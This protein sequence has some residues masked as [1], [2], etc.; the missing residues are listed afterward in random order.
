LPKGFENQ[1]TKNPNPK[2]SKIRGTVG[3]SVA[4]IRKM[5]YSKS[6][7][8]NIWLTLLTGFLFGFS[9]S[10]GLGLNNVVSVVL[11]AV[12]ATGVLV[13]GSLVAY[14]ITQTVVL[15]SLAVL[16]KVAFI[17]IADFRIEAG[18]FQI[19]YL[20]ILLLSPLL[21]LINKVRLATN[22]LTISV[23][24]QLLT[25]LM[26]AILVQ[27]LRS[28]MPSNAEFAVARMFE[29]EDNAGI[30]ETLA[31]SLKYGFTPQA[32]QFGEFVNSIYLTTAG[33]ISTLSDSNNSGLL[34]ALTHY[35]LTL[36]FMAWVPI[37]ALFAIVFSG[38]DHK[39]E[40][41]IAILFVSTIV[42]GI[43]FWPFETLGHTSVISG[44]LFAISLLALTLNRRF[45]M[46]HAIAYASLVTSFGLII[47]T[48]WFPLMPFA[49]ATVALTY[50]YLLHLEYR[51]GNVKIVFV[52]AGILAVLIAVLL[53][54]V[55]RLASNSAGYLEMQGGTRSPTVGL[56]ILTLLLVAVVTWRLL[57]SPGSTGVDGQNLFIAVVAVLVSSNVYLLFSA[58]Q[59]NQGTFGYGATKYLLTTISFSLPVFWMLA[60]EYLKPTN[61]RVIGA[62]GLVL[63]LSILMIQPDSRKVP[64]AI[65]APQLTSRQFLAPFDIQKDETQASSI[66]SAIGNALEGNP[67][68]VICV[69]DYGFPVSGG[70]PNLYSYFCNRWAGSLN[71]DEE[72]FKWGAVPIG[73]NAK[74][75]LSD[76]RN[77]YKGEEVVI[78]R[79][80]RP[81]G[82]VPSSLDAS[83]TWWFEYVD[84]SWKVIV[85]K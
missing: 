66:A 39:D 42:L 7:S 73:V 29:G 48:T 34:P 10:V 49:A 17:L 54:G 69:S 80:P 5:V 81:G 51:K 57:R 9:V 67:D 15:A 79:I 32:A 31:G 35:N 20:L 13:T 64:A 14:L 23:P 6:K 82:V 1:T 74:E 70:E 85:T 58:L 76:F 28:R 2:I 40:A 71:N 19:S 21:S 78:I 53:P 68:H 75:T 24:V 77:Q 33:L 25:S 18:F 50:F 56:T 84:P 22:S 4:T 47:G 63:I 27:F 36:L 59:G 72:S 43:L 30:V 46:N 62:A 61:F 26:F 52:L 11:G 38:R 3:K 16:S 44:G 83:E 41:K 45:A 65:V 8:T 60:V 37:A 55:L 12:V